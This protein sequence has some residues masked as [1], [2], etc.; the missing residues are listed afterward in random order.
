MEDSHLRRFTINVL[1]SKSWEFKYLDGA[2]KEYMISP[3]T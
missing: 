3:P 1:Y 2:N